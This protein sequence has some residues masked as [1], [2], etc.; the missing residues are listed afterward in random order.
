MTGYVKSVVQTV[1]FAMAACLTLA[2]SAMAAESPDQIAGNATEKVVK[3]LK[4]EKSLYEKNPSKFYSDV[5]AI[6]DPVIAFDEMARGVMGKYAHRASDAEIKQFSGEFRKSLIRFYS[7]AVLTFDT[8][9]LS[10]SKVEPV[11]K[12]LL[13]EYDAGK[14]RSIP[15]NLKIRSKDNEYAMSYSMMKK[16]GE[17]KIR[18][19]VVEGINIGIQFRNQFTDA[20]NRYRKVDVVISKWSD[21]MQQTES[22]QN[23]EQSG[24]GSGKDKSKS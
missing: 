15:V 3:L 17:W 9:Q 8:S 5:E 23:A 11:S 2:S 24:E 4:T 19:I 1:F 20:V 21:I 6:I 18:N 12:A 22:G 14:S 10:V 13:Q 16:D 7:K